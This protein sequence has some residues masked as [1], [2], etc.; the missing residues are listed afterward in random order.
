MFSAV[1]SAHG[2]GRQREGGWRY[3]ACCSRF[4][5]TYWHS[6]LFCV[7]YEHFG[8]RK[9]QYS[10]YRRRGAPGAYR[11]LSHYHR[12]QR[13]TFR[14]AGWALTF[15]FRLRHVS[16]ACATRSSPDLLLPLE[17]PILMYFYFSGLRLFSLVLVFRISSA[18]V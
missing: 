16:H 12:H 9:H 10:I 15:V 14:V 2:F 6:R 7:Q 5:T 18:I 4:P 8:L 3:L 11:A 13:R 17:P 1:S